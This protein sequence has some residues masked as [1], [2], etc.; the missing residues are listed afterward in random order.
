MQ[1]LEKYTLEKPI[2]RLS[3]AHSIDTKLLSKDLKESVASLLLCTVGNLVTGTILGGLSQF[4][5]CRVV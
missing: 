2:P 1:S 5:L 3:L 4:V